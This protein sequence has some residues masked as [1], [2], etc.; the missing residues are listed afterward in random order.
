MTG[1]DNYDIAQPIDLDW[2]VQDDYEAH[3]L[4]ELDW[5]HTPRVDDEWLTLPRVREVCEAAIIA[6]GHAY[7]PIEFGYNGYHLA[8]TLDDDFNY[9]TLGMAISQAHEKALPD[10]SLQ[11]L[12]LVD[13][14]LAAYESVMVDGTVLHAP[15]VADD[16]KRSRYEVEASMSLRYGRMVR[17][18][19]RQL[20]VDGDV[21]A[22]EAA[23]DYVGRLHGTPLDLLRATYA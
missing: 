17:E 16:D 4:L 21:T 7:L 22:A 18:V 9:D 19:E 14:I 3:R 10:L 23:L 1:H 12:R 8:S 15:L 20:H 5:R 11:S 6:L 2:P 13:R